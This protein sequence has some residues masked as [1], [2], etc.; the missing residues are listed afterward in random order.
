MFGYKL[1]LD[2]H[3]DDSSRSEEA[4]GPWSESWTNSFQRVKTC[5][6]KDYPDIIT[7]LEIKPGEKCFIVWAEYS[8][9]DSFGHAN[10]GQVSSLAVFKDR[11]AAVQFQKFFSELGDSYQ[12]NYKMKTS[13]DQEHDVYC[14]W[15]GY[16]DSL[17]DIHIEETYME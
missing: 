15:L 10:G 13:D 3:C 16:F 2:C 6:K 9:G 12:L 14:G 11:D 4:Y 7:T 17:D 8:T 1:E 5:E